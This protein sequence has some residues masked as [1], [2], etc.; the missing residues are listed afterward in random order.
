[1]SRD[2]LFRILLPGIFVVGVIIMALQHPKTESTASMPVSTPAPAPT[3]T[4]APRAILTPPPHLLM[5]DNKKDYAPSQVAKA[6]EKEA[7]NRSPE[8]PAFTLRPG[9]SWL[10]KGAGW[11]VSEEA[12]H[13]EDWQMHAQRDVP[14]RITGGNWGVVEFHFR[15]SYQ[16]FYTAIE[17]TESP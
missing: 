4:E 9:E 11:A 15:G 13:E 17:W 8:Y 3:A 10:K 14:I 5:G 12:L 6:Q 16:K 2:F 1:M 7:K